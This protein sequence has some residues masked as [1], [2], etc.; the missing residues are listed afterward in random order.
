M[1]KNNNKKKSNLETIKNQFTSAKIELKNGVFNFTGAMSIADF[2]EKINKDA[3]EIIMIFFKKGKM[4]SLNYILNEEEIAELCIHYNYDF[5]KHTELNASN[6]M[7]E[8]KIEDDEEELEKRP[9][10]ITIMGHVDHGKTT[11]LDKIRQ[12]SVVQTES[13]GITQHTGAY[14][15]VYD[16]RKITFLDTPGHAAFAEMRARGSKITDIIVLVV[17]ADDGVMPQTVEAINH[18]KN[19]GAP[20]IVFINKIDKPIKDIEKIKAELSQH[21]IMSEEWGGDNIFVQGSGLT[22]KGINELFEAINLQADILDLKANKNREAIGVVIESKIEKGRGTVAS[23]IV[24]HG[25][26]NKGDFIVAGSKYGRIKTL[27]D[28]N[29]K[30]LKKAKPGTPVLITGLNHVPLAGD[31]FFAFENEKFAKNLAKDKAIFDKEI[32]LRER[33]II[34]NNEGEKILNFIIKGDVYGTTEAIKNSLEKLKNDEAQV[35]VVH[36]GVGE[37]NE[38]DILLAKTSNSII[39][40]FKLNINAGI[41][42]LA[43]DAKVEIKQFDVIYKIIEDVQN[44]LDALKPPKFEEK[45]IGEALILKIFYYSKV[46]NI[47]G[48]KLLTGKFKARTKIKVIRKNKVIHIGELDSLRRTTDDVK[49]VLAGNEFGCHIYKFNDIEVDDTL[50]AFEQVEI[51]D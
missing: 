49:E 43:N 17:A 36:H 4:Y 35:Q 7:E 50:I 47:A 25:T 23:L 11:L 51:K 13:G 41:K 14:Q 8:L 32:S 20:I 30:S 21:N 45:I 29:G 26:L 24:Q 15:I 39:Y 42:E 34:V 44:Q 37:I 38:N 48:C 18:A 2:A 10:I 27:E 40:S 5:Q 28:S 12:T 9:P 3:K 31:K 19:S 16:K 46:G 6:F 22:G 33:K 1:A